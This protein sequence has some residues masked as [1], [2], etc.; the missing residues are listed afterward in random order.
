[1]RAF[2]TGVAG[3]LG[4]HLADA[5]IAQGHEVWG[6]D[7]GICGNWNNVPKSIRNPYKAYEADCCDF[8]RMFEIIDEFKPDVLVHCAA[9]AHEGLSSFSPSFITKNIYEASVATFSAAIA[10][11]VK[12]I[13]FMSSMARYGRGA[14]R[15]LVKKNKKLPVEDEAIEYG[16]DEK[17]NWIDRVIGAPFYEWHPTAPIDP[18]GVAKVAAE[19]TLKV[20]CKTHGVNYAIA[21]PHN[22]IGVRQKYDDPARNV[23]SIMINRCLQGKPPIVYGDGQQ[24]RCFSPVADCIPSIVKMVEGAADGEIVNIGPDKGEI[25]VRHLAEKICSLTGYKG[26]ITY[27]PNRPN[28]VKHAYCSSDKA[29]KLLGYKEVNS[30]DFCIQQMINDIKTRGTKPFD[31]FFPIEIVN[32]KTPKTWTERLM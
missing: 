23:C 8:N 5:L 4:S 13:V 26:E 3:F 21:V 11:G 24:T 22:I 16:T 9:T 7:S 12:R 30:L 6:N 27:M 18:Y 25:T 32:E 31:Y 10:A 20:L 17:G 15:D 29:R 14:Y 1:M 2:V 19:D 28:E